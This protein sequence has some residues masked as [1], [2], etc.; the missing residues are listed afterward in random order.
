MGDVATSTEV[1]VVEGDELSAVQLDLELTV[2]GI[3]HSAGVSVGDQHVVECVVSADDDALTRSEALRAVVRCWDVGDRTGRDQVVDTCLVQ[4]VDELVG[5]CEQDGI[6]PVG[7]S[8][9]PLVDCEG[10]EVSRGRCDRHALVVGVCG[11]G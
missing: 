8:R 2:L 4:P 7:T 9:S 11:H 3:H 10:D 6:E 5:A 1:C